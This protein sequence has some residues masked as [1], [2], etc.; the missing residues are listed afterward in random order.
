MEQDEL[1]ITA[2]RDYL[3]GYQL[4]I[5]ML[6]IRRYERKRAKH[7]DEVCR[8]ANILTGSE[9]Y[10]RARMYEIEH[11]ITSLRNGRE[12]LILYSH[13]IKGESIELASDLLGISRR[14]GYRMHR[15][16]LLTVGAILERKSRS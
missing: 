13:Y 15:K 8:D 3:S 10:W 5:D 6:N 14:T 1:R 12:K 7:F 2:A 16:G 11:L 4:C 9:A